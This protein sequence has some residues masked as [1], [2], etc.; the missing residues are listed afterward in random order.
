M[1]L[2]VKPKTLF[3][4]TAL[5]FTFAFL[6]FSFFSLSVVVYFVA[7]PLTKRAA[8]DLSAL[9]VLATQIWVE[10][11]PGTRPDF[12]REMM[13]RH[14]LF[15]GT[16]GEELPVHEA[17]HIYVRYLEQALFERTSQNQSVLKDAE[18]P[19]WGWV[20]IGMGGRTMRVGFTEDRLISQI[21][22]AM[23]LMV[24][25]G[26][27]IAV[28]TSLLWVRRITQPLAVLAQATTRI[29][30]GKRGEPLVES[31][32]A[33]LFELTRNFNHM[34]QQLKILMDNRT[35]LL[36]GIS[37]DLRTPIARMQLELELLD[38][39]VDQELVEGMRQNL[40]EM[41]ELITMTLQFSR[42]LGDQVLER[43]DIQALLLE[44]TE[45]FRRRGSEVSFVSEGVCDCEISVSAFKR[46]IHNLLEN[47]I[48]YS[49]D[50]PVD[51]RAS[52][53]AEQVVVEVID[54]GPGIPE[55]QRNQMFQ[56]FK[57]LENSRNRSSGGSGLGLAIVEQLCTANEWAITLE[58]SEY[59]GTTAELTI[60]CA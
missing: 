32:A 14:N 7:M 54:R 47:A 34:E 53:C 59:G 38:E 6:F 28:V 26:T 46:V 8:D 36:A 35:T 16:A 40:Q 44:I 48:R 52:G 43:V 5:G 2:P 20:D 58:E 57:R 33:E 21:P 23:I 3:G 11:P 29:G 18:M 31:G 25:M 4:R 55:D 30:L 42:G 22:Q 39:D 1:R 56:P 15:I 9:I 51:I 60:Y 19:E 45:D 12:E 41:N 50:K 27:L 13:S 37:H 10:L 17:D 24:L 49:E